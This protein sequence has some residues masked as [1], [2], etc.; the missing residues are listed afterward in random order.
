MRKFRIIYPVDMHSVSINMSFP[1][2]DLFLT[3]LDE[4]NYS[5]ELFIWQIV[6]AHAYGSRVS[7][8]QVLFLSRQQTN[9]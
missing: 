9:R 4:E 3:Y 8:H 5:A 2:F 6:T 7:S 1:N